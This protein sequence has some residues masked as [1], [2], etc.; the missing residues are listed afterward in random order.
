MPH[1]TDKNPWLDEGEEGI[2]N[3]EDIDSEV[4]TRHYRMGRRAVIGM[5]A[6]IA[7]SLCVSVYSAY[8]ARP[9]SHVMK[10]DAKASE[11]D[12]RAIDSCLP[13]CHLENIY[14]LTSAQGS[15]GIALELLHLYEVTLLTPSK[16]FEPLEVKGGI[17]IK[18]SD[19]SARKLISLLQEPVSQHNLA[20]MASH[21]LTRSRSAIEG[22]ERRLEEAC[23]DQFGMGSCRRDAKKAQR[24]LDDLLQLSNETRSR[25]RN[26][27][28]HRGSI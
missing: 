17:Q 23:G 18:L 19:E 15:L 11:V 22:L 10:S 28:D 14:E 5:L 4:F 20:M 8:Q 24:E 2:H 12:L 7:F 13:E 21:A 1:S 9:V 16:D 6:L 25:I 26:I 3:P 27:I